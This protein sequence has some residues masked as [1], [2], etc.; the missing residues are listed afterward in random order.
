MPTKVFPIRLDVELVD[1]IKHRVGHRGFNAYVRAL[2]EADM[3][4]SSPPPSQGDPQPQPQPST[5]EPTQ[6]PQEQPSAKVLRPLAPWLQPLPP[7]NRR[8]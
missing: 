3:A 6:A 2:I 1:K 4:S 7:R 5:H 8:H